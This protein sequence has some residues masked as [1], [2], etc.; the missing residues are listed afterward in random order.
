MRCNSGI[1]VERLLKATNIAYF[2]ELLATSPGFEASISQIPGQSVSAAA[3]SS[4]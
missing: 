3:F 4:V 1:H 2:S